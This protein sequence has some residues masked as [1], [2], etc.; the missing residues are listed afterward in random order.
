MISCII[1]VKNLLFYLEI[2][3]LQ[4][5]V[6]SSSIAI[7]AYMLY[8]YVKSY[9]SKYHAILPFK[10]QYYVERTQSLCGNYRVEPGEQCD[11]GLENF[12]QCATGEPDSCCHNNCTFK[13]GAM[14]R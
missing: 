7:K 8:T 9:F 10:F 13:H 6:D 2:L 11:E 3:K 14:C 5:K 12:G 1:L 4:Q